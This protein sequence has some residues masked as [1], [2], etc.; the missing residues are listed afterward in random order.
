MSALAEHI[1]DVPALGFIE[2][3]WFGGWGWLHRRCLCVRL[4]DAGRRNRLDQRMGD[5]HQGPLGKDRGALEHVLQLAH[6]AGPA[7]ALELVQ[8]LGGQVGEASAQLA[9]RAGEQVPGQG[10]DVVA[11]LA[12]SAGMRT[13]KTLSR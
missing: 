6:V 3:A 13:G 4:A 1:L 10:R 8:R 12:R 7:V 5:A 9:G 11:A 2:S